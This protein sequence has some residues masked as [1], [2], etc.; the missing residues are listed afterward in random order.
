MIANDLSRYK[1]DIDVDTISGRY[2][3]VG[4]LG[5]SMTELSE[6]GTDFIPDGMKRSYLETDGFTGTSYKL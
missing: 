5:D 1:H 6:T 2:A 4:I 3:V